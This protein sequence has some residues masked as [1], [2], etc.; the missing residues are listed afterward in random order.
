MSGELADVA[1]KRLGFGSNDRYVAHRRQRALTDVCRWIRRHDGRRALGLHEAVWTGMQ[2][3]AQ[4]TTVLR[5]LPRGEHV[6]SSLTAG[7]QGSRARPASAADIFVAPT[8][9]GRSNDV[10]GIVTEDSVRREIPASPGASREA[11]LTIEP[12]SSGHRERLATRCCDFDETEAAV[13]LLRDRIGSVHDVRMDARR[14]DHYRHRNQ[15]HA[16]KRTNNT[17]GRDKGNRD[18]RM[19]PVEISALRDPCAVTALHFLLDGV[20]FGATTKDP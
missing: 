18:A 7:S 12:R 11:R 1:L 3:T 4:I 13:Q 19:I 16:G 10:R 8:A 15:Y 9:S 2:E 17:H 5:Y 6:R 14:A 20:K